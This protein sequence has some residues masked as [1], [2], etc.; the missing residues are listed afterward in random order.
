MELWARVTTLLNLHRTQIG[1]TQIGLGLRITVAALVALVLAVALQVRLPLWAVLTAVI[2]TQMSVGRSLKAT[3]D[4]LLGTV[5]GALYGG[6][7]AVLVPHSSEVTLLATLALAIAPLAVLAAINPRLSVA[8]I[9]SIIVLLVP[10]ITHTSPIESAL[11]RILEVGLG[12]LTGLAVSFLVLPS[13]A[14]TLARQSASRALDLMAAALGEL[15]NGMTRGLDTNALHRLQDDIG[16]ALVALNE[17]AAEAEQEKSARLSSGP[18]T[19]PL[20]R[21]LLRLRHDLVMIGRSAVAPLPE[22][23][24]ARV[25]APLAALRTAA[26]DYL[27]ESSR[28]LSARQGPPPLDPFETTLRG[29]VNEIAALRRDGLTRNLPG[30]VTERFFALGFGLE[31]LHQNFKDLQRVVTEWSRAGKRP[32]VGGQEGPR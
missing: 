6:A 1:R 5:G 3:V 24:Q 16:P 8:P 31:Q 22:A 10:T 28:A 9:T 30:D 2:V 14:Y 26:M 11:D 15:L 17:V 7:I 32:E 27:R 21:T 18:E 13:R 23:L 4:Y 20:S 25:G 29:Y 19:G 12:A